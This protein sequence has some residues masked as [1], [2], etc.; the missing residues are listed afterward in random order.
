MLKKPNRLTKRGSF[1]YVYRAGSR[2]SERA[3]TLMFVNSKGGVRAGFSV[4]NKVGKAVV[5]NTLKRRLRAAFRS[6]LPDIRPAQIVFAAR[7]GAE[8]MPYAELRSVM[9]RLLCAGGLYE[10]KDAE[11]SDRYS[12]V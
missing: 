8:R 7:P 9:E 4:P 6:F 3:L 12:D 1:A 10:K 2:R 5:R 11:N